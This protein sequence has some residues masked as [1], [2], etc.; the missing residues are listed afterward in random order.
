MFFK[1]KN[2]QQVIGLSQDEQ[3]FCLV[4][5]DFNS[6]EVKWYEKT[7][8]TL[9]DILFILNTEYKQTKVIQSVSDK[10]IWRKYVFFPIHYTN[11]MI[12]KQVI[13]LLKQE[14][15]IALEDIYFDYQVI[16]QN[17]VY[18]II[19]YA[20]IKNQE[21]EHSVSQEVI[22]D[23]ESFCYLRGIHHLL[24]Q[25]DCD[26]EDGI[27]NSYIFKDKLIQL[28]ESEFCITDL[29]KLSNITESK[30]LV[31][32][33]KIQKNKIFEN[34]EY[35]EL[36]LPLDEERVSSCLYVTALGATLWNGKGLI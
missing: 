2:K 5:N 10:F 12:Y 18:K 13:E 27:K 11:T 36:I 8:H 29:K 6:V 33:G 19:L 20:L 15:P 35:I 14:L 21:I 31:S 28:E 24:K 4:L 22:L 26:L 34:N 32:L 3:Y 30:R 23:S 1:P 17:E 25:Q 9:Q 7:A 16:K